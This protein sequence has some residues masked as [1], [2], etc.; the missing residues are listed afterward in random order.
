[1]PGGGHGEHG[2]GDRPDDYDSDPGA[3]TGA[4]E[5]DGAAQRGDAGSVG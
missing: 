1:M 4:V 5:V 3:D 2:D